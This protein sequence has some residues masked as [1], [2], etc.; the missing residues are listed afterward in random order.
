PVGHP[1]LDGYV[2]LAELALGDWDRAKA[3]DRDTMDA[4][5]RAETAV[6][7]L[8]IYRRVFPIG[9]PAW[10]RLAGEVAQRRGNAPAARRE[11]EAAIA[12]AERLDMWPEIGLGH[13]A[14][15]G[16]LSDDNPLRAVHA[17]QAADALASS[18]IRKTVD[19][20]EAI[21]LGGSS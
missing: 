3:R 7:A 14:L 10:R 21:G 15:R 4:R 12:A 8:D 19:D 1:V 5:R 18:G 6:H 11:F 13:L 20:T 9:V 17:V 2:A 16:V